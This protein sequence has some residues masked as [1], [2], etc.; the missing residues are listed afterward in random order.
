MTFFTEIEKS[1]LKFIQNHKRLQ[2]PNAILSQKNWRYHNTWLQTILQNHNNKEWHGIGTKIDVKT[3]GIEYQTLS[4]T[5]IATAIWFS[6]KE[7]KTWIGEQISSSINSAGKTGYQQVEDW[8]NILISH[9]L[10]LSIQSG[11]KILVYDLKLKLL[12]ERIGNTL[13]CISTGN[14]FMNII[15]TASK[16]RER[17]DKYNCIKLKSCCTTK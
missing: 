1:A 6:K 13:Q 7:P 8:N 5:H 17:I 10:L 14:N 3:K 15:L 4:Q 2:I 16:S 12:Q 9:L 11:S